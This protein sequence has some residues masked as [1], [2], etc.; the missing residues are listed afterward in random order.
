MLTKFSFT[1]FLLLSTAWTT[2]SI[3][4]VAGD[5]RGDIPQGAP[6]WT[7]IIALKAFLNDGYLTL[8]ME[9]GDTIPHI[10]QDSSIFQFLLDT[11]SDSTT[12]FIAG[13]LG[14][15]HVIQ[16]E[17]SNWDGSPWFAMFLNGQLNTALWPGEH[18]RMFD[19]NLAATTLTVHFSLTGLQ[20]S[21]IK[22]K[23][24]VFYENLFTDFSPDT[25]H[26]TLEIGTVR[27]SGLN[28]TSEQHTTFI[29]PAEFESVLLQNRIP[30]MLDVAY[31]LE[32]E[33]TG[34]IPVG[35]DTLRFIFHPLYG[36]AAIE[37]DPIYIG[38]TM[39]G[40]IPLWFV[41]F[42][43]MGHNFCNA[44]PHFGQLYPLQLSVP[45]G[46]LPMN[47]LF[48]E[49]FASLPAMYVYE[50]IE[51]NPFIYEVDS[52][53]ITVILDDW[54]NVKARFKNAWKTYK[55]DPI[56]ISLNPDIIDG[57]FLELIEEYGWGM[58]KDFYRLMRNID[59]QP[60]IFHKTLPDDTP[61]LR[62]TRSTLTSAVLSA[63]ANVDM[64]QRFEKWGFPIDSELFDIAM[65]T[66]VIQLNAPQDPTN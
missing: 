8:V 35:G 41:Y 10:V 4:Q 36:G 18:H 23:A 49:A 48:Y 62:K 45:Q 14:V 27:F 24:R 42:H 54:H 20:W 9:M 6:Q 58:V 63:A 25:S 38:P 5:P 34:I 64:N 21:S 31:K 57:M 61:D 44:S 37:G 11:D 66:F 52:T 43:E 17:H 32:Q 2:F 22:I 55:D 12:G 59:K 1:I 50:Q 65:S 47:I 16:F 39:W 33:L 46:P 7:D 13:S 60:S 56:S 19:W 28:V 40:T 3:G 26:I 51:K 29:Y 15:D 30:L 53:V